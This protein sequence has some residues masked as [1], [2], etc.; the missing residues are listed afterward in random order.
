MRRGIATIAILVICLSRATAAESITQQNVRINTLQTQ[1]RC[2]I[3]SILTHIGRQKKSDPDDRFAIFYPAT[4]PDAYVQCLFRP[5]GKEIYCEAESGYYAPRYTPSPDKVAIAASL[6]F[7]TDATKGNF[8]LYRPITDPE[9]LDRIAGLIVE[10]LGRVYDLRLD[11]TLNLNAPLVK[12]MP[13][14]PCAPLIG[15][16]QDLNVASGGV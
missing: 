16:V 7:S 9:A 6:G 14:R 13:V 11:E 8:K 2:W 12:A 15:S 5:D 3:A 1:Y 10:T 4:R